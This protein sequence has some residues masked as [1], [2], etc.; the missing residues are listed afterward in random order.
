MVYFPTRSLRLS[1]WTNSKSSTSK[2]AQAARPC[3]LAYLIKQ[4]GDQEFNLR[5][6]LVGVAENVHEL[7]GA[8]ESVPRYLKEIFLRPLGPQDLMDVVTDAAKAISVDVPKD[9]LYRI[10][11]IGNGF[12]HFAHLIGKA[13]L[14]EAVISEGVS[15]TDDVYRAGV[16]RAVDDS[17]EELRISYDAATQRGEDY[18]KH[19]IW[20]LAHSD[21]VDIRINEWLRLYTELAGRLSWTIPPMSKLKNAIGNFKNESYGRILAST[22]ARY[23]TFLTRYRYKRFSSSLMRGHVR[24]QAEKEGV[25]L[26]H[27]AGL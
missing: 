25:K 20:A 1:F 22:P 27:Q 26:G 4:I 16:V 3:T 5:F 19:L 21:V 8:H 2:T 15:V 7:I 18:F 23:G 11:I 17:F 10:A 13:V 12:P 9:L 14:T 6:V 24:L